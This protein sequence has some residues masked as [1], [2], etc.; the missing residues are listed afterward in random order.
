MSYL[1]V[2]LVLTGLITYFELSDPKKHNGGQGV[3]HVISIYYQKIF[4]PGR[5]KPLFYYYESRSSLLFTIAFLNAFKI[6]FET[7]FISYMLQ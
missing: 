5:Q 6:R 4:K 2:I 7:P 3:G 1:S